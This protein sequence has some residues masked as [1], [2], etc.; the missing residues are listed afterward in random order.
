MKCKSGLF[1]LFLTALVIGFCGRATQAQGT[2]APTT[3]TLT[4]ASSGN[5]TASGSSIPSGTAVTLTAT[6]TAGSSK[7]TAGQVNFCDAAVSYCT[8]I[9]R[10]GTAQV[11]SAGTAVIAFTPAIGNH[12]YKAIYAG[13]PNGAV[14]WASSTSS[15]VTLTVTGLYPS[16]TTLAVSY[17]APYT[18]SSVVGG[19]GLTAPTG[20][21]SFLNTSKG[22]AALS[23]A[24]LGGGSAGLTFLDPGYGLVPQ[25]IW[26]FLQ[27]AVGDFNGDGILDIAA[28]NERGGV[29]TFFQPGATAWL[30]DGKGKVTAAPT[31][32]LGSILD[33][34]LPGLY[35]TSV[36]TGDFNGDGI[37]DL[38][39]GSSLLQSVII[40]PGN[41]D[42]T[43]TYHG[44]VATGGA[45][46]SFVVGDFNGDGIADLA[47][48]N[49]SAGIVTLLLGNGD[50]SFTPA[51]TAPAATGS[52]AA[53]IGVGDFNGDGS[54]DLAVAND[55]PSGGSLTILLGSGMGTFT[56]AA[57]P[58]TG[59]GPAS[60]GVGDFNGDGVPDLAVGN[61]TD[62][63][64]TILLGNGDGTFAQ[65]ADSPLSFQSPQWL[66][67]PGPPFV[68]VGDFNADGKADVAVRNPDDTGWALG[69][70]D[71]TFTATTTDIDFL[72]AG[73]FNGD[74]ATDLATPGDVVLAVT[75]TAAASV[76]GIALPP[77]TGF[78]QVIETY[79]GD[80]N[81][82]ASDTGTWT[83][84]AAQAASTVSLTAS[85]NPVL[86][87]SLLTLTASVTSSGL[88]PTG[89]VAFSAGTL[90]E[91]GGYLNSSGIVTGTITTLPAG[92][93]SI[94][95]SYEGDGNH[96]SANSVPVVVTVKPVGAIMPTVTVAASPAIITD[97]QTSTVSVVVGGSN[98]SATPT[99]VVTLTNAGMTYTEQPQQFLA[100]GTASFTIPAAMLLSGANTLTASYSGDATYAAATATTTITVSAVSL[101]ISTPA[102][103]FPGSTATATN[104]VYAG[105][106]YSGTVNLTCSLSKSPAGAQSLPTCGMN[107]GSVTLQSGG[108]ATSV[109][110]VTT[111]AASTSW[112]RP[113]RSDG[114]TRGGGGAIL[115][116]LVLWGIPR[117]RRRWLSMPIAVLLFG[118]CAT[119]GCSGVSTH[120][121]H[122]IAAT[123]AGTY[124]FTVTGQD[125]AT[126]TITTS[127]TVNITVQ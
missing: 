11:T 71:G 104:T 40:L 61:G 86:S 110:T 62:G 38:A 45:F 97:Q 56:A 65:A 122:S 96:L 125:S 10:L 48:L 34:P 74:G 87:G 44:S 91:G 105:T 84:S 58:A 119:I 81:Y 126:S 57:S 108:S 70:G 47:V 15:V 54:A 21:V 41:G 92:S 111:T 67:Y 55:D 8:D 107:P 37:L 93:Y 102:P 22:N 23:T 49:T 76:T 24:A 101:A 72:A 19:V 95:A 85:P 69:N 12:S 90:P 83:L 68:V 32:S 80:N 28:V 88:A 31:L 3:T 66:G 29:G 103:V 94:M 1:L 39:V 117:R 14:A 127:T 33:G 6:V 89:I 60:I 106:N 16:T 113:L 63:T 51:A 13:T 4:I 26:P 75:Q 98:G 36:A 64:L 121:I 78:A 123:T 109:L 2:A 18:L 42:G 99:G 53:A 118:A 7:I 35:L 120:S 46:P 115:A 73:D 17:P 9:H 50:G 25:V 112:L 43:F 27:F 30:G 20:T 100:G 116:V 82:K 124:I 59:P 114:W 79:P 5:A 52:N 77:G